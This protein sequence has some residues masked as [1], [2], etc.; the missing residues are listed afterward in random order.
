MSK[1]I[2]ETEA[3][4]EL[5]MGERTFLHDISNQLVV[6]QGMGGFV[7]KSLQKRDDISEK[8]L[9]RMEKTLISVKNMVKMVQ[10]RRQHLHSLSADKED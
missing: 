1:E 5:I 9:E 6:A 7:L 2:L 10:E 3:G 4:Q 8:E